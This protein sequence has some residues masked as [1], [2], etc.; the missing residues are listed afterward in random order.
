MI[1]L[2]RLFRI[3]NSIQNC[4]NDCLTSHD[5]KEERINSLK[6]I[7]YSKRN[8]VTAE[9]NT[10]KGRK[11]INDHKRT[12]LC[13]KTVSIRGIN[14]RANEQ[15]TSRRSV[16]QQAMNQPSQKL[17]CNDAVFKGDMNERSD[18]TDHWVNKKAVNKRARNQWSNG[19]SHVPWWNIDRQC[20]HTVGW[21]KRV[22]G[23]E[24]LGFGATRF[25]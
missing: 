10:E 12:S 24:S 25:N 20:H 4:D 1:S 16:N 22:L 8:K 21:L 14:K 13:D 17:L 2:F 6:N 23:Q 11:E 3:T 18:Q 15:W 19:A 5:E 7:L 9:K